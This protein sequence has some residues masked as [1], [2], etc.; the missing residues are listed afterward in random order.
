MNASVGCKMTVERES[1]ETTVLYHSIRD[2]ETVIQQ[3][4]R[5]TNRL[6]NRFSTARK[7][8]LRETID[9]R[10]SSIYPWHTA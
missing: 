3:M 7:V 4:R 6:G 5:F 10:N 1:R 2:C 8:Y 9:G